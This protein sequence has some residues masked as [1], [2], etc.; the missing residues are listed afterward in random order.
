[1]LKKKRID[2]RRLLEGIREK[3]VA[4]R[5]EGVRK[6][7]ERAAT[8]EHQRTHGA[9]RGNFPD[10]SK[11]GMISPKTGIRSAKKGNR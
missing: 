6:K 8:H 3:P 9:S 7:S 5:K 4:L 2:L 1:M 11:K 10:Q